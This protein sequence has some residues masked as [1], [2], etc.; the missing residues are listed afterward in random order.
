MK[1]NKFFEYAEEQWAI[2][3]KLMGDK[4]VEYTMSSGD[5]LENFK[6][7]ARL[8]DRVE[9][10]EVIMTYMLK[11]IFSIINFVNTGGTKSGES[12]FGRIQDARNYLLLLSARLK[13]EMEPR[14]YTVTTGVPYPPSSYS[15]GDTTEGLCSVSFSQGV[16]RGTEES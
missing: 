14:G 1:V 4:G 7:V 6:Q 3:K 8:L 13:E 9:P 10:K 5:K 15:G 16:E 11:H 12:I 2:E